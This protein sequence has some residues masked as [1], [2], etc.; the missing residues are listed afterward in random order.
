MSGITFTVSR[1]R[2]VVKETLKVFA[3]CDALM[4]SIR[5]MCIGLWEKEKE[6]D[7]VM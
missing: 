2:K 3:T 4:F 6:R 1:V 5:T 7:R